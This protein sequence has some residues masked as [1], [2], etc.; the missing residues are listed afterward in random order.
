MWLPSGLTAIE[1]G[2]HTPWMVV[3]TRLVAVLITDTVSLRLLLT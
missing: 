3:A 2:L 1:D